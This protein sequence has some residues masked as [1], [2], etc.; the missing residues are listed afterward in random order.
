[1]IVPLGNHGGGGC[2]EGVCPS[3]GGDIFGFG[4]T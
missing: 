2:G 4:G 1:M 3:H